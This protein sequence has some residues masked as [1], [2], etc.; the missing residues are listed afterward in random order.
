MRKRNFSLQLNLTAT[1]WVIAIILVITAIASCYLFYADMVRQRE[2]INEIRATDT[3]RTAI[4]ELNADLQVIDDVIANSVSAD[5]EIADIRQT[6][7]R[8]D[9][10]WAATGRES[11]LIE[12]LVSLAGR[13]VDEALAGNSDKSPHV[14]F[15]AEALRISSILTAFLDPAETED[16]NETAQWRTIAG[17]LLIFMAIALAIAIIALR[18]ALKSHHDM[19]EQ[20]KVQGQRL[21]AMFNGS[22]D[23]MLSLD[24]DGQILDMNRSARVMLGDGLKAYR[25]HA[26][27]EIVSLEPLGGSNFR[28]AAANLRSSEE[29]VFETEARRKNG[30]K[31]R[32]GLTLGVYYIDSKL[33][34]IA[35]I[36]DITR[37]KLLE[38]AKNAFV[39]TVS[40]ELR[41]PLTSIAGSLDLL[42]L[43]TDKEKS[44]EKTRR[45]VEIAQTNAKR[46]INLINDILDIEKLESGRATIEIEDISLRE[47]ATSAIE[48]NESLGVARRVRLELKNG[49]DV[50]VRADKDRLMQVAANFISNAVKF[51]PD[52]NVVELGVH[53]TGQMGELAV[54][55]HGPGVPVDFQPH[56][57]EKF[58]QADDARSRGQGSTG[59]G[60]AITREIAEQHDGEVVYATAKGGGAR[61]AIRLPASR[62][63]SKVTAGSGQLPRILHFDP[64]R[65]T[66]RVIADAF[67]SRAN[68][69]SISSL[70]EFQDSVREYR[71]E[72]I[73]YDPSSRARL[74]QSELERTLETCGPIPLIAF[75]SL[76]REIMPDLPH[77][78]HLVKSRTP[79]TGVVQA[80][81][82]LLERELTKA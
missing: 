40:H 48:A 66:L 21:M 56:L 81:T 26:L 37:R 6:I 71:P 17:I 8:L 51:S 60:L 63:A 47:L 11:A 80:A 13:R 33:H 27:G 82:S 20:A 32:A 53:R 73:I 10:L 2:L 52:G 41:T 38:E 28:E 35:T 78:I 39:S 62:I 5:A 31:F 3:L 7:S 76:D 55:D 1:V 34:Y 24:I 77:D 19:L 67:G 79:V 29:P 70:A 65:D 72:L 4:V 18:R 9:E 16:R 57:F 44:S 49:E 69:V 14:A 30:S 74:L 25:D 58:S 36:R 42:R 23:G 45:L 64:D 54:R 59:L 15:Q 75:T 46:L 61:F 12:P 68:I 50:F 22:S 43:Q